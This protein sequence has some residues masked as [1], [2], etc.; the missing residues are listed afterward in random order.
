MKIAMIVA[1]D[2]QGVIGKDNDL[3]WKISADLQFFKR[4][5][6]GKPIIMGRNT[7]ESIG[8]PL[9]GRR[10]VVV[11]SQD[12]Y[13]AEGCDV[14]HSLE[15]AFSL[16]ETA[17]EVMIMGGA[18]LYKQCFPLCD[19]LYI[20]QVHTTIDGGDTWFPDWDRSEWKR[21]SSEDHKADEKNQYDYSFTLFQKI[22][23]R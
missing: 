1:M 4:T 6:M 8:R 20:T 15:Q 12:D 17:E 3:P 9:P 21:V 23:S 10:N 13:I 2:E 18:S 5:T 7:L 11:T 14:V 22:Q 16:C 19:K